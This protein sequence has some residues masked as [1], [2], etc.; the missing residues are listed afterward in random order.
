[1]N[2]KSYHDL[3]EEIEKTIAHRQASK[4]AYDAT[5]EVLVKFDGKIIN[6]RLT[7]FLRKRLPTYV[8]HL[9]KSP[10]G[11][12]LGVWGSGIGHERRL[13]ITLSKA[14]TLSLEWV[15]DY[16]KDHYFNRSSNL[17]QVLEFHLGDWVRRR[18]ALQ[19]EERQL[20]E[21]MKLFDCGHLFS[22]R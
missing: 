20:Q 2:T 17:Q 11:P 18:D 8:F 7:N 14:S 6:E 13:S 1:M 16:H 9:E 19:A 10:H 15:R 3:Y 22:S 12:E 5:L 4:K 21:T